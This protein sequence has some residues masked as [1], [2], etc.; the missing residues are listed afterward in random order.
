MC[1][2][3]GPVRVCI[4][5]DVGGVRVKFGL[6]NVGLYLLM[7]F[8]L[9]FGVKSSHLSLSFSLSL[10]LYIYIYIYI[11]L[12]IYIYVYNPYLKSI[13]NPYQ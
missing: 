6:F 10:S 13:P 4:C 8:F 1:V 7:K 12:F 11:Y 2:K 9:L 3:L 5:V